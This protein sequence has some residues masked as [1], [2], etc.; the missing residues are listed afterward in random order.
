[1]SPSFLPVHRRFQEISAYDE[2]TWSAGQFEIVKTGEIENVIIVT[3]RHWNG[4]VNNYLAEPDAGTHTF[5]MLVNTLQ[6]YRDWC[7][8]PKTR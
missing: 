6:D 1:M 7:F 8:N 2:K 5:N 4:K 3:I